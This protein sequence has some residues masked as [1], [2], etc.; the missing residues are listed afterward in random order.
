MPRK[1]KTKGNVITLDDTEILHIPAGSLFIPAENMKEFE[2]RLK[3][4]PKEQR[5]LLEREM[6]VFKQPS[7]I[8]DEE[9]L[10][11]L[12]ANYKRPLKN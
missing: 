3:K 7:V 10:K 12:D 5:E 6:F 2:K 4:L 8:M 11:E 9:D 1:K